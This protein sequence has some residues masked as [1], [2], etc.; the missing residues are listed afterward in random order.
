MYK[1]G[2]AGEWKMVHSERINNL[3]FSTKIIVF[4]QITH[5]EVCLICNMQGEKMRKILA[6]KVYGEK[7][8][9]PIRPLGGGPNR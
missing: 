8:V 3:F 2:V 6:E 5:S 4:I 9:F 7:P 1:R